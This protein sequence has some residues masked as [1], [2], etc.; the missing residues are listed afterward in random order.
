MVDVIISELDMVKSYLILTPQ[1]AKVQW[2]SF[3]HI[4][5]S[6]TSRQAPPAAIES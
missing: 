2:L 3:Y 6:G 1:W 4:L 5:E